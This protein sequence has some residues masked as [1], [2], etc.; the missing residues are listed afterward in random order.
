VPKIPLKKGN[1]AK[2]TATFEKRNSALVKIY[3]WERVQAGS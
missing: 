2:T 3:L 1:L